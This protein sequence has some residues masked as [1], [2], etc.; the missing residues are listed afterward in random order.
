MDEAVYNRFQTN[1]IGC[2][3]GIFPFLVGWAFVGL[4]Y[5]MNRA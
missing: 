3:Q 4:F 1:V 2:I 5:L